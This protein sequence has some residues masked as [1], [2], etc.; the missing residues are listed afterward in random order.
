MSIKNA[1]ALSDCGIEAEKSTDS[2]LETVEIHALLSNERR[3]FALEYLFAQN[4]Q[5]EF[6]AIVD[7][8]AQREL[9]VAPDDPEWSDAR[10]KVRVSVY[11]T[12]IDRLKDDGIVDYERKTG[13]IRLGKNA[14]EVAPFLDLEEESSSWM[15]RFEFVLFG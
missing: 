14:S 8:V 10:H 9:D 4:G 1:H 3:L 7:H 12:H 2:G 11:Q 6:N 15:D 5:A 13:T